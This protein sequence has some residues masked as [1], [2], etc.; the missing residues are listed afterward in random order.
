MWLL[1]RPQLED[2]QR[3]YRQET[4]R[5]AAA[6]HPNY[7]AVT[8]GRNQT[9]ITLSDGQFAR[10]PVSLRAAVSLNCKLWTVLWGRLEDE[11]LTVAKSNK[12]QNI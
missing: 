6:S 10:F 5:V 8:Q 2:G 7:T 1:H 11:L 3:G 12:K 9:T 4:T